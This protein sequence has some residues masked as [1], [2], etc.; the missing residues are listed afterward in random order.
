MS[1]GWLYDCEPI[2]TIA[3]LPRRFMAGTTL[4]QSC[5]EPITFTSI[6]ERHISA[7]VV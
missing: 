3:P 6:T 5:V 1:G 7:V 2:S 4:R